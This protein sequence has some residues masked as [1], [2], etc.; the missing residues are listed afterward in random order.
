VESRP[1][2]TKRGGEAEEEEEEEE[3]VLFLDL[4]APALPPPPPVL[5]R[6]FQLD[7]DAGLGAALRA[8][9]EL[10]GD[11]AAKARGAIPG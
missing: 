2:K 7:A 6:L 5:A 11:V 8:V 10:L 4:A 1:A 3:D 9:P